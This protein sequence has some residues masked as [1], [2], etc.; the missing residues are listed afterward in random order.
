MG[1]AQRT[2]VL[3]PREKWQGEHAAE[4]YTT[5][6][7]R[8]RAA[9]ERD[10]RTVARLLAR[11]GVRRADSV[12]DVPSGTGRLRPALE[13]LGL[14]VT[15]ADISPAMLARDPS[16]RSLLAAAECLPFRKG[17][18]DAVVCC[19]LLHHLTSDDA[20]ERTIAELVRVS[21]GLVL[22]SFWDRNSWPGW[23]RSM[24][25]RPDSSGRRPIPKRVLARCFARAGA[26]IIETT[27]SLRFLSMQAFAVA[28]V[29]P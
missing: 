16:E 12:L 6:R 10:P 20:L 4:R 24:G 8:S 27:H 18:F 2:A 9:A 28:R 7:F 23:R 13:G 11:H 17:S 25:L 5:A 29:R 21:R 14:W 26:P 3:Q 19:R 1:K 15:G 22:A